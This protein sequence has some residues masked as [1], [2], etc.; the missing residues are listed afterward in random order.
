MAF[1]YKNQK[2]EKSCN[3]CVHKDFAGHSVCGLTGDPVDL[4]AGVCD[5]FKSKKRR[6]GE[7]GQK[8]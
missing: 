8:H 1:N 2:F 4:E 3:Q 6:G 7:Y 5:R